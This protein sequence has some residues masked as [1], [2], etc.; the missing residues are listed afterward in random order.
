MKKLIYLIVVIVALGLIVPGCI[1][2]IPPAEQSNTDNLMKGTISVPAGGSIQAAIDSATAGDIIIVAAGT[3][4][5]NITI[6]KKLTIKGAYYSIIDGDTN[7]DGISDGN[8]IT[9][10]ANGVTIDGFEIKNGYNGIIGETSNSV[11]KNNTIH[12]NF[13]YVGSNGVGILLWGKNDN[14]VIKNNEIYQNDRQ[15]IFIGHW[16]VTKLSTGNTIS[17]NEIYDNGLYKEAN[18]PDA[19][20]Y[21]IQLWNADNNTIEN[22]DIYNH[23]NWF[24]WGGD[25]DFA[26][27]IYLCA[28]FNNVVNSNNLHLNNYGVGAWSAGRTPIASNQINFNNID[29]NT[30]FGV[31]NFDSVVIDATNNWWG[32]ASG[33]SGEGGRKNKAGKIIGKGDAVS[34]HVN[35]DPWLSHPITPTQIANKWDLEG[36]FEAHP[37]YNWGGLAE[38]A[39]WEYS[40]HIKEAMSGEFSVGSIHFATTVDNIGDIEV[41]GIVEQT[42]SDYDY[43]SG[44]NLAAAGRAE[45]DN[46]TYNFLFLYS[47]RAIW[48]TISQADLEPSW[49]QETVWPGSLREYQLHSKVPDETFIMDPK[50][51]H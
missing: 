14:N 49:S 33:P 5:E 27:G 46:V 30:G 20:M 11:I 48:F 42:K 6:N 22:N 21:G 32:H 39:T 51:I 17:G 40:I 34:L 19:S 12:D 24:P 50:N 44:S 28:S 3:Y 1:P 36:T 16:D 7:D 13:N 2:V 37:G 18:G 38:G 8:C 43:W 29:G 26:Q 35:W 15:G 10:S 25:F 31:N 23:D 47:E 9:I 45:Y 41:T 4:N